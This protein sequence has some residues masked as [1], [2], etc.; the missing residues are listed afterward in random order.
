MTRFFS[1]KGVEGFY[2]VMDLDTGIC[3]YL[4]LEEEGSDGL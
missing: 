1:M 2:S 4:K 3:C